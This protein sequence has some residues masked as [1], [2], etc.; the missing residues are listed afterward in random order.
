MSIEQMIEKMIARRVSKG[1]SEEQSRA[2]FEDIMK[3]FGTHGRA[4]AL[5]YLQFATPAFAE[6]FVRAVAA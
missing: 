1:Y 5:C 2:E 6:K 3:N 4:Y